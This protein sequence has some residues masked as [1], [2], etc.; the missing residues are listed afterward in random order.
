MYVKRG[1]RIYAIADL[2]HVWVNLDAQEMDLRRLRAGQEV[3][4]TATA[5][6]DET[7]TGTIVSIDGS[8]QAHTRVARVR[9]SAP[10]PQRKLKPGM[11]V[12][13]TVRARSASEQQRNPSQA[14]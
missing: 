6:P 10:N 12:R 14:R 7:F 13:A 8:V 4:F 9:V 1:A 11:S 2:S 3:R 5:W